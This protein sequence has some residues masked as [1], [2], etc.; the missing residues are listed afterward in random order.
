MTNSLSI[1]NLSYLVNVA[2]QLSIFDNFNRPNGPLG[3]TSDGNGTW[4]VLSG[5]FVISNNRASSSPAN[6]TSGIAVVNNFAANS[7]VSLDVSNGGGDALYFRVVDANNWW[8]VVVDSVTTTTGFTIPVGITEYLWWS[9]RNGVEFYPRATF[10]DN[11]PFYE[12]PPLTFNGVQ[13]WQTYHHHSQGETHGGAS[14]G[15]WPII[16]IWHSS[17]SV[18]PSGGYSPFTHTHS[19]VLDNCGAT[20][21]AFTHVHSAVTTYVNQTRFTQTGTETVF[22]STT[23]RTLRLQSCINGAISTAGSVG[24]DVNSISVVADGPSIS[25]RRNGVTTPVIST[26]SVT[27]QNATLHGFGRGTTTNSGTAMD[28]FSCVPIAA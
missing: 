12:G 25:V 14:P 22:S 10:A 18:A 19:I 16:E 26:S 4:T 17:P 27:H 3:S 13:C 1:R 20:T 21:D 8:R 11:F 2:P 15:P 23:T 7:T 9:Y 28:N 5:S 24:G 6:A